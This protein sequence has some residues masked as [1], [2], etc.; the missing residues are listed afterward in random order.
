MSVAANQESAATP[1]LT[2]ARLV[3]DLHDLI[4]HGLGDSPEAEALAD[5]MDE[6]WYAM[7]EQEQRR[8]RGL[9]A[10]LYALR[11]GGPK[12]VDMSPEQFA[13]W[14]INVTRM[15]DQLHLGDVDSALEFFRKPI[16]SSLPAH[17]IPVLQ[18][19]CWERAGDLETALV[20]LKQAERTSA[21]VALPVVTLLQ[22]I[23][24]FAEAQG[25]A[26]KI[27]ARPESGP[28]DLYVAASAHLLR[29]LQ[30]SD[31]EAD[32]VIRQM[33]PVLERAQA[34]VTALRRG[35][36]GL[37]EVDA[38]VAVALGH[39][40]E[41]IGN[42][43]AALQVYSAALERS[44]HSADL[45]VSRGLAQY[46]KSAGAALQDFHAAI[47]AGARS[48]WPG[49]VLSRQAL[50]AGADG[51]ALRLA[52]QSADRA[53]PAEVRAE[54]YQ[55]IAIAQARLGQPMQEV[56]RNFATAAALDPTNESIRHNQAIAAEVSELPGTPTPRAWQRLRVHPIDADWLRHSY[57]GEVA[58]PQDDLIAL[59]YAA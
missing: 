11:E 5:Q 13:A 26:D 41:R 56:L 34:T 54:V 57:S 37:S 32:P 55:T 17:F 6:P 36:T 10:D 43:D 30:L 38:A 18:A 45:L 48:I 40:Y 50:A 24:K 53:G 44:P 59:H 28:L 20:F 42:V 33:V 25:Y 52:L 16:P 21:D 1:V 39:C 4:A 46:G 14:E 3:R 12:R 2:Y 49:Y 29:V 58:L 19:R 47:A 27:I 23:G 8:M 51:E 15:G 9:S 22:R 7:T 35:G 31:E